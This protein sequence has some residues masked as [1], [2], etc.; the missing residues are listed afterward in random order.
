M[1]DAFAEALGAILALEMNL[2]EQVCTSVD[3]VFESLS[4]VID[5]FSRILILCRQNRTRAL[6]YR[7][8][9]KGVL[10]DT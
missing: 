9:W 8:S 10:S 2:E 5:L 7:K 6:V 4:V 3:I 1:R